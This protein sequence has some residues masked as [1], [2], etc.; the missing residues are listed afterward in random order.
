[1]KN[2]ADYYNKVT[3]DGRIFS[4]ED[5]VNIPNDEDAFYRNAID[6]QYG[7]IGFPRDKEL[8]NSNDVVYIGAYTREDGTYVRAHYRSKNGHNFSNPAK[9]VMGTPNE[10]KAQI[11]VFVDKWMDSWNN[12]ETK[13]LKGGITYN[14]NADEY[15]KIEELK[16]IKEKYAQEREN[17]ERSRVLG[18]IKDISGAALEIGS[19]FIPGVGT[20]KLTTQIAKNLAPKIGRRI[21]NEIG[22]GLVRGGLSGTIGG[23]GDAIL[24]DKNI[25]GGAV[26][27][28]ILGT[29]A[30]GLTGIAAGYAKR[31]IDG[32]GLT[33][34]KPFDTISGKEL[35]K[36]QNNGKQYYRDYLQGTSVQKEGYGDIY[37]NNANAGKNKAHT[38]EIYPEIRKQLKTSTLKRKSNDKGET[39]RYYEH[40]SN[41]YKGQELNHIIEVFPNGKSYKMTKYE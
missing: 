20:A 32:F 1:M 31:A 5:V 24:N 29:A 12:P 21:A 18:N 17:I 13:T 3:N 14:K 7:E 41:E 38:M 10:T 4:F 28:G 9:P 34:H 35:K 6:Y 30:G 37:F 19:A 15:S 23:A 26:G 25:I 11:D 36:Y 33:H 39:D 27:G 8:Q 22:S 2:L 40:L 16:G